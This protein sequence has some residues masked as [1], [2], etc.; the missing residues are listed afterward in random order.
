MTYSNPTHEIPLNGLPRTSNSHSF[1]NSNNNAKHNT[2]LEQVLLKT[3]FGDENEH[4]KCLPVNGKSD[5]DN[6]EVTRGN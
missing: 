6:K 3:N 2:P 4:E 1:R 5:D